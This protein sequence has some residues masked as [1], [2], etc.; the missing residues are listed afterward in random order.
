[1]ALIPSGLSTLIQT[2]LENQGANGSNLQVFCQAVALGIIESIV[3][4]GFVTND[5]GVI[6]AVG[7]G[8]GEGIVGLVGSEMAS[9]ALAQMTSVGKNAQPL[10]QAIMD[11][12]VTYLATA[13]TLTTIDIPV[14]IG[15]GTIQIGSITVVPAIMTAN[16]VSALQNAGA[17]GK[18][19]PN[20]A[21]AIATGV[22]G[23]ISSSGTGT[24]VITIVSGTPAAPGNGQG[25]GTIT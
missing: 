17:K 23:G 19:M 13:A 11:A 22:C 20:L 4:Q 15:V 14:G 25:I 10:F 6:P 9:L 12:V 3:G 7:E 18:N 16:I 24:V 21:M 5:V 8:I 1:M 2:N